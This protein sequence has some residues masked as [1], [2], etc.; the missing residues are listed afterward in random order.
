MAG[1]TSRL[2]PG[3]RY[4][5]A[6]CAPGPGRAMIAGRMVCRGRA[7]RSASSSASH[8]AGSSSGLDTRPASTSLRG[9]P[10]AHRCACDGPWA[11]RFAET[12]DPAAARIS[13]HVANDEDF[14]PIRTCPSCQ[15]EAI[16]PGPFLTRAAGMS[17]SRW[18]I[19][20]G[21]GPA[22]AAT[23]KCAVCCPTAAPSAP[24]C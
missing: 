24:S 6:R 20:L 9:T 17:R 16:R 21:I 13:D 14:S 18:D 5:S 10:V 15:S 11:G 19:R 2:W 1:P 3:S 22:A 8:S 4:G 12:G 7:R 23:A